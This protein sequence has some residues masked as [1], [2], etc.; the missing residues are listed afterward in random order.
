MERLRELILLKSLRRS[1]CLKLL[2]HATRRGLRV[3]C[4]HGISL[5]DEHLFR[6]TLFMRPDTFRRRLEVLR[7][8]SIP[9]VPLADAVSGGYPDGAVVLTLDDGWEGTEIAA[10]ILA[11]FGFP[12][13]LYSSTYYS[14]TGTQVF[15]VAAAYVLWK[16][17]RSRIVLPAYGVAGT[18]GDPVLGATLD[19]LDN[20]LAAHERQRLLEDLADHA[21]VRIDGLFRYLDFDGL[22]RVRDLGMDVQLHTHRHR[23]PKDSIEEALREIELNRRLL[24]DELGV[25]AR[26][27]CFPS[28]F[29]AAEH[30]VI[31]EQAGV[32]TAVVNG[33]LLNFGDVDRLHIRR[34][35]DSELFDTL[36]FEA[37][38][39]GLLDVARRP[40]RL[41]QRRRRFG[42]RHSAAEGVA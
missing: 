40:A 5:R 32:R 34:L 30:D 12:A 14:T 7:A 31:L 23:L 26:H 6:P 41:L 25:D 10:E 37:A 22:R 4:Y 19:A 20:E 3:L 9:V 21:G 13:T 27:F 36:R 17:D 28:S 29:A 16:T 35:M 15:N 24:A 42:G 39:S 33:G 8:K 11:E 1:G 38:L 2:S 18:P